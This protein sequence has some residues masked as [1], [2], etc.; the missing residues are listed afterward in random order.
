MN[1]TEVAAILDT[2]RSA[3]LAAAERAAVDMHL[4]E[5]D[6]CAAAW[7]AQSELLALRVPPMPATLPS[8]PCSPRV[9]PK[10]PSRAGRACPS[11]WAA[12]YSPAPRSP[13]A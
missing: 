10:A 1:C 11:S 4:S 2:H 7:L 12:C 6:D 3:R 5:C 8:A 13:P 9:P